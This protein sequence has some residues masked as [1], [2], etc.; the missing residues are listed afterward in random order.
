[1]TALLRVVVPGLFT[2]IQDLGRPH[3]ITA[4]VPPGGAM[5]RF[6]HAAANLLVGNDPGAATLECT[7]SGPR[8]VAEHP[9]LV[10]VTGSGFEPLV[11]D[12]RAPAWTGIFLS[13]GDQLSFGE[14]GNGAR[15]YIAVAGGIAGDRW[16]GSQ[17]TNLLAGR[18]GMH[19]R[20]LV[21]GD[22]IAATGEPSGPAVSGREL[23][24]GLR[25]DYGSGVLLAI[26]GPHWKR[27]EPQARHSLFGATFAVS[28][29]ADR[30]GYRLDG[31]RL[32]STGDELLSFGLTV[33]AV[34]LT[35]AGQPIVLMADHQTAGGYPV[36][37]TV[38][39]ASLPVAAQLKPGAPLRFAE[40]T[41]ER[42][43]ELRR[44]QMA[45][46]ASLGR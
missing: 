32:A 15:V 18:G 17:S 13:R 11:N 1:M 24:R 29:D 5:D 40:V 36:V 37:A 30:M 7:L 23:D 44:A 14:R 12:D 28:R 45:A 8:L 31:P 21:V 42:A 3:A 16:L 22:V 39:T 9:C 35:P 26:P 46:L 38:V 25:P 20:I 19:G 43:H 4:G 34:Q 41:L 2:T 33:G 27:L 6:A 10:A